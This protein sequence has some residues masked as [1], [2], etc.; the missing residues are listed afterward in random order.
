MRYLLIGLLVPL[1]ILSGPSALALERI[2]YGEV[3]GVTP[4]TRNSAIQP[5]ADCGARPRD[6][7]LF[8]LLS[9][10][11]RADCHV[12]SRS[13]VVGYRVTYRWDG[14]TYTARMDQHPG[15]EIPLRLRIR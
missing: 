14:R 1:A 9:W 6:A 11:L 2:V 5:P 12:E 4:V 8:T 3:T 15:K 7:D 13:T 10:D